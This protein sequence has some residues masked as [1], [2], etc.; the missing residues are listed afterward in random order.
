MS[1]AKYML[2]VC[3][4]VSLPAAVVKAQ[5][6][7]DLADLVAKQNVLQAEVD[8][9]NAVKQPGAAPQAARAATPATVVPLQAAPP[10]RPR[11]GLIMAPVVPPPPPTPPPPD[12]RQGGQ[13]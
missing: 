5:S 12:Q 10:L 11:G 4:L 8:R 9:L 13:P 1:R 3:S 7:A 6:L 2:L